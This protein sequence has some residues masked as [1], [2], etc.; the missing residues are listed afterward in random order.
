[1]GRPRPLQPISRKCHI[2][3]AFHPRGDKRS[4]LQLLSA[5]GHPTLKVARFKYIFCLVAHPVIPFISSV[6]EYE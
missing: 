1:M 2:R 6:N 5:T 4:E 3:V